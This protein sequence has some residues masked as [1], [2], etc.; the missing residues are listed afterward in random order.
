MNSIYYN[1]RFFLAS[2]PILLVVRVVSVVA[3]CCWSG[4]NAELEVVLLALK[5][6]STLTKIFKKFIIYTDSFSAV[7]SLQGKTFR[8]KNI[9]RFYNL[10]KNNHQ[11]SK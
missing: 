11:K 4:F 7:E 3:S 2:V 6:F 1:L 5:K 10:L 9:K 8:S